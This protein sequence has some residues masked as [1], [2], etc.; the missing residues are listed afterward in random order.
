MLLWQIDIY[1]TFKIANF[2]YSNAKFKISIQI[3]W[4]CFFL[5]VYQ[6][7]F[8]P[9]LILDLSKCTNYFYLWYT[10]KVIHTLCTVYTHSSCKRYIRPIN[11]ARSRV[12]NERNTLVSKYWSWVK[13]TFLY[14]PLLHWCNLLVTWI[15]HPLDFSILK[16]CILVTYTITSANLEDHKQPPTSRKWAKKYYTYSKLHIHSGVLSSWR[17]FCMFLVSKFPN[18]CRH[19]KYNDW[20]GCW[21][22]N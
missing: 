2:E 1:L 22:N 6:I 5:V 10:T 16:A 9:G 11:L 7:S 12:P 14:L 15:P 19:G 18:A 8:S 21:L 17:D 4:K 20:Q 3:Q 13:K